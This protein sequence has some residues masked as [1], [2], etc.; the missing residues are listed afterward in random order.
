[1]KTTFKLL[2]ILYFLAIGLTNCSII[3]TVDTTVNIQFKNNTNQSVEELIVDNQSIGNIDAD[4]TTE[5]FSFKLNEN[6]TVNLSAIIENITYSN[7]LFVMYIEEDMGYCGVGLEQTLMLEKRQDYTLE[8]STDR[9]YPNAF[10][11][12]LVMD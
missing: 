12:H 2:S 7:E 4:E 10:V 11:V 9:N 8:L 3:D 6:S 5:Y 1:M